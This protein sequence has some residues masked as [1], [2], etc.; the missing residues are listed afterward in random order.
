MKF[1][2]S[3]EYNDILSELYYS[4]L[5]YSKAKLERASN[6]MSIYHMED[7][8]TLHEFKVKADNNLLEETTCFDLL[9]L[10]NVEYF[11]HNVFLSQGICIGARYFAKNEY[12]FSDS[13]EYGEAFNYLYDNDLLNMH[14]ESMVIIGNEAVIHIGVQ[15][16]LISFNVVT[17]YSIE[18]CHKI[19]DLFTLKNVSR[20]RMITYKNMMPDKVLN[21]KK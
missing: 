16:D 1:Q 6:G 17:S 18:N 15:G 12:G 8:C 13:E 9:D 10:K 3:P 4:N 19:R 14:F 5:E 7:G 2:N 21:Y 20:F 11:E